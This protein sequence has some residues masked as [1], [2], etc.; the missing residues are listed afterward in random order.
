MFLLLPHS[1]IIPQIGVFN[2][3]NSC[4]GEVVMQK[5]LTSSQKNRCRLSFQIQFAFHRHIAAVDVCNTA[6]IE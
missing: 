6:V 2:L 1:I 3:K 4:W 5:L